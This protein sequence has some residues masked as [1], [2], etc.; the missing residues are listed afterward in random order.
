MRS[1][2]TTR[3]GCSKRLDIRHSYSPEAE[4]VGG[5]QNDA[6]FSCSRATEATVAPSKTA[7]DHHDTVDRSPTI[8]PALPRVTHVPE[9]CHPCPRS[10]HSRGWRENGRNHFGQNHTNG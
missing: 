6:S 8:A 7:A 1:S 2:A 4:G 9:Q 3:P 10:A 5:E